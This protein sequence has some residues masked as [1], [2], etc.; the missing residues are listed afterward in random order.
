[1]KKLILIISLS[2]FTVHSFPQWTWQNPLPQGNSLSSVYFVDANTGYSVGDHGTILKTTNGGTLWTFQSSGITYNLK[3][4]F[5]VGS[6]GYA[7]GDNGTLLK[8]Y[9]GGSTWNSISS[10]TINGLTSVFFTDANTGYAVGGSLSGGFI[11]NTN[12]GGATWNYFGSGAF[13]RLNSI[14]FLN[15]NTGYAVG[16]NG[17]FLKTINGGTTWAVSYAGTSQYLESVYFTD[18]NT[19]Y[20]AGD[21]GTLLKTINGGTS[22][23]TL[24]SGT[25]DYLL[26]VHFTDSN[27]GYV[28]GYDYNAPGG[29]ILHTSDGGVT[30]TSTI[31]NEGLYSV[32][33]P[34]TN[35]GYAVGMVGTMMKTSDG[36]TTWALESSRVISNNFTTL[37][38]I[39]FTD[40]NTG[41]IVGGD[42]DFG[43]Y[44]TAG[45]ILKTINGGTTWSAQSL[46]TTTAYTLNSV[47]FPDANTGYAVGVYGIILKTTNAGTTWDSIYANMSINWLYSVYFI[48]AYTGFAVGN[49]GTIIKTTNGGTNWSILSTPTLADLHSVYFFDANTGF[50]VGDGGTVLKTTNGGTLWTPITSGITNNLRCIVFTNGSTGYA[51]G[52]EIYKTID[53]GS[54]WTALTGMNNNLMSAYF[55]NANTG[56]AVGSTYISSGGST[57][58]EG[59]IMKTNNGGLTWSTLSCISEFPLLATY[60]TDTSQGYAVGETGVILATLN[61]GGFPVSVENQ[62][63]NTSTFTL[64]PNPTNNKVIIT[65]NQKLNSVIKISIFS[66]RGEQVI[67]EDF[68]NQSRIEINV[69]L[70]AK[71]IYLVKIQTSTGV[72]TKKLV[73]Q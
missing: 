35:T 14:Y 37:T 32:Y 58:E 3:S 60:F 31:T 39:K 45:I 22:W 70:F 43:N 59:F 4:V 44:N 21:Y 15:S 66:M 67:N 72:E 71:G 10:G 53:G 12:D 46:P 62:L 65:D 23:S 11:I 26:S 38:S 7:V 41:Y 24:T 2:F 16:G 30:W 18:A 9:D 27:N 40:T 73:I 1:M 64:Y 29:I 19:G 36:G 8:T 55:I 6:T 25:S 51:V 68:Q 48:D 57:F 54:T 50:I 28:V 17:T 34:E 63:T 20:I 69:N 49:A 56:Y 47:F 42:P 52:G 33:S 13:S 5:F 61:G